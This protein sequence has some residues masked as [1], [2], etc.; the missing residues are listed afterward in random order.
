MRESL[1]LHLLRTTDDLRNFAPQWQSL[2]PDDP[3]AT[4]FQTAEWLLPWWE[5]FSSADLRAAVLMRSGRSIGVLPMYVYREPATG[6][7]KLMP[8]GVG[9][10]DYLDGV[11][12]PECSSED[13]RRAV[14]LLL[15]SGGWDTLV[16]QQ[17]R[18]ESKLACALQQMEPLGMQRAEAEF[19]SRMS[20][21]TIEQLPPKIRHNVI[22]YANRA[23]RQGLLELT[24][25][26]NSDWPEAFDELVHLHMDRWKQRGKAGVLADPR[27]LE[28]HRAALPRL[29]HQGVL[30]LYRL[31]LEDRTIGV[32]Y[33]LIDPPQR[34]PRTQYIYLT[35]YSA[36]H[37]ELS[38]GTLLLAETIQL[39]SHEG[40]AKIDMLRGE[41]AYKS[42][43]HME[44]VPTFAFTLSAAAANHKED[45][46]A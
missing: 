21:V 42:L 3:A 14:E 33:S 29:Q 24:F 9:T 15:E 12:L 2:W 25:A 39:A 11:F 38:P 1:G 41:E 13:I 43:W 18:P 37:A 31:R 10:T 32:L 20:A 27:V 28:W 17:I 7:R 6:E 22:Y 40:V 44:R 30:R 5:Q 16:L 35:A 19:C 4:P 8:L 34:I 26:D 46:A 36:D 45:T 23:R